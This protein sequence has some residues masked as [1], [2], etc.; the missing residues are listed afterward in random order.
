VRP[1]ETRSHP[2]PGGRE[3]PLQAAV[4]FRLRGLPILRDGQPRQQGRDRGQIDAEGFHD[5]AVGITPAEAAMVA[6]VPEGE[7]A[8]L[9][10]LVLVAADLALFDTEL[11]RGR[12]HREPDDG[13]S[14]RCPV[15]LAG[16]ADQQLKVG[17]ERAGPVERRADAAQQADDLIAA[18]AV[19][20]AG[21]VIREGNG[22]AVCGRK[23]TA[24]GRVR[25]GVPVPGQLGG[26]GLG[27]GGVLQHGSISVPAPGRAREDPNSPLDIRDS[28]SHISAIDKLSAVLADRVMNFRCRKRKWGVVGSSRARKGVASA[29][30][31]SICRCVVAIDKV[32]VPVSRIP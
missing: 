27:S 12:P 29:A 1:K 7:R 18:H 13:A 11:Y 21:E 26:R 16:V 30:P 32:P 5:V 31:F 24:A 23:L 25:A 17:N 15:G 14:P 6:R 28:L 20:Q 8:Q 2:S 22:A 9:H 19:G 3:L 4:F 10:H